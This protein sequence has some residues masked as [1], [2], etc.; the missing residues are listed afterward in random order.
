LLLCTSTVAADVLPPA[1]GDAGEAGV[2]G[3][4]LEPPELQA[5]ARTAA[6]A[7]GPPTRIANDA[8]LD[9][10]SL[11]ICC[12]VPSGEYRVVTRMPFATQYAGAANA[13]Q[14]MRYATHHRVIPYRNGNS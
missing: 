5:A 2:D 6:A 14:W 9:E 11:I 4:L 7:S 13:V 10:S 8:L 1:A 3:E 12:A